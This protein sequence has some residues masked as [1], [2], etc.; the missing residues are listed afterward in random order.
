MEKLSKTASV[1]TYYF[2]L[3]DVMRF[4]GPKYKSILDA[5]GIGSVFKH[6]KNGSSVSAYLAM[7][8]KRINTSAAVKP[9]EILADLILIVDQ[10]KFQHY[11]ETFFLNIFEYF[12]SPLKLLLLIIQ[13]FLRTHSLHSTY[14]E[15]QIFRQNIDSLVS[16][17]AIQV[18]LTWIS[19]KEKDFLVGDHSLFEILASLAKYAKGGRVELVTPH[20]LASV[21]QLVSY[22]KDKLKAIHKLQQVTPVP[23]SPSM[24]R[25]HI[26]MGS[27]TVK[28]RF[29]DMQAWFTMA[30]VQEISDALMLIDISYYLRFTPYEIHAKRIQGFKSSMT[31]E[32]PDSSSVLNQYLHRFNTITHLFMYIA[33]SE[34]SV[35]SRARLLQK[36]LQIM[37]YLKDR[38]RGVNLESIY[39]LSLVF[40]HICIKQL[41]QTQDLM[42]NLLS[43]D[44]KHMVRYCSESGIRE[45][46][47]DGGVLGDDK[48]GS[49]PFI[50]STSLFMQT[51]SLNNVR[52]S[53]L[54]PDK[55]INLQKM[56][57]MSNNMNAFLEPKKSE[58]LIDFVKS[59]AHLEKSKLYWLLDTGYIKPLAKELGVPSLENTKTERALYSL[60]KKAS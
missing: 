51:I 3:F 21:K 13:L 34:Y 35:G 7:M 49:V 11:L 36:Y 46:N 45:E 25:I 53:T 16:N 2:R 60:S 17:R 10:S 32:T 33:L 55:T 27:P 18:L 8:T 9:A 39:M 40:N 31:S 47:L 30:S 19:K 20:K 26:D 5:P 59:S 12:M 24:K 38:Q 54:N 56:W 23:Q 6:N 29:S 42:Q 57:F 48:G 14:S 37:I 28:P 4:L 50:P 15:D 43:D 22:L 52:M 44:E 1:S 58:A 41:N